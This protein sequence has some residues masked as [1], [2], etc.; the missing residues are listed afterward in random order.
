MTWRTE[1]VTL[2]KKC[3][4]IRLCWKQAE[5]MTWTGHAL[6][7]WSFCD[8]F[9]TTE[10]GSYAVH[11]S[12]LVLDHFWAC[13]IKL[14]FQICSVCMWDGLGLEGSFLLS[15]FLGVLGALIPFWTVSERRC[16]CYV[17]ETDSESCSGT[18]EQFQIVLNTQ[19]WANK[20]IAVASHLLCILSLSFRV[21][22]PVTKKWTYLKHLFPRR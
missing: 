4:A 19:I 8:S 21:L 20:R 7:L 15:P 2:K 3:W 9:K 1:M 22:H 18:K 11:G 16:H 17:L 5:L 6:F 14:L 10:P 13:T 12:V